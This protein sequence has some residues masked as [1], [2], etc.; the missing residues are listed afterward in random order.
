[1]G[2]LEGRRIVV[3]GGGSG[4]GRATCVRLSAEGATVAVL[5]VDAEAAKAVA[6]EV[7]GHA[8]VADVRSGD[9]TTSAMSAAATVMGGLDGLV[10]NAGVG[11]VA[12]L[13]RYGDDEWARLVGVNLS[14]VFHSLRA[15]LP[16]IRDAGGGSVVTVA[17]VSGSRPTRGESPYAAAK[18]GVISLTKS[19]ALEYAPDVRANCVSP[20]FVDT[21]LTAFAVA[22]ETMRTSIERGTPLGRVGT[23]DE[24]AAVIAFLLSDEASYLTGQDLVVDGGSTLLNPQVDPMLTTFLGGTA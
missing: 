22:D 12:H 2:I 19:A 9:E 6:G 16:L 1:M 5:D 15:A 14:G 18:A 20:G 13:H 3:T 24:I 11:N 23:A 7:G 10:A 21:P 4:I 17:S 8:V